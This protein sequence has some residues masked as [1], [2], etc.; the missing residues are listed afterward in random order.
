MLV[1][2]GVRVVPTSALLKYL[3]VLK[4]GVLQTLQKALAL[5]ISMLLL[6]SSKLIIVDALRGMRLQVELVLEGPA[7]D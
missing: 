4:L 2:A 5:V 1:A 7:T 6:L 3:S